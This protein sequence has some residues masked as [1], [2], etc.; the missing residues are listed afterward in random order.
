[1]GFSTFSADKW[2][3]RTSSYLASINEL[4][5]EEMDA[6]IEASLPFAGKS[7]AGMAGNDSDNGNDSRGQLVRRGA[8]A[9]CD[10]DDGDENQSVEEG[11]V[12]GGWGVISKS[13]QDLPS[14]EVK[15]TPVPKLKVKPRSRVAKASSSTQGGNFRPV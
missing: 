4:T 10:D 3:P 8:S 7:L 14:S 12:V 6:I 15:A 13:I 1:M 2:G 5:A 11:K 9:Q